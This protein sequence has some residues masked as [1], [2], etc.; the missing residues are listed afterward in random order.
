MATKWSLVAPTLGLVLSTAL[1]IP[2]V[3]E[4]LVDACSANSCASLHS[5]VYGEFLGVPL[6]VLGAVGY[7][8]AVVL[9][10]TSPLYSVLLMT[11]VC[12]FELFLVW[13]MVHLQQTHCAVC[14]ANAAIVVTCVVV[15][16]LRLRHC[17]GVWPR[18]GGWYL[19]LVPFGIL[20]VF[21]SLAEPLRARF[22][23]TDLSALSHLGEGPTP[24]SGVLEVFTSF[25]CPRCRD[26]HSVLK[27]ISKSQPDARF[28]F[29]DLILP[30]RSESRLA[31]LV[32]KASSVGVQAER[33]LE[34]RGQL[35]DGGPQ[36]WALLYEALLARGS[37][38]T[39]TS[40]SPCRSACA[41]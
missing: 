2:F 4:A 36:H 8:V 22:Q 33:C 25:G 17:T 30:G 32:A 1:L 10:L 26:V 14:W 18:W 16:I 24:Q 27:A 12:G 13:Q 35:H 41:A 6:P 9:F 28:V 21:F 20:A 38:P 29:R 31:A 34:V 15:A 7:A 37:N 23:G 11:L 3:G 39:A 5:G 19:G 40:S